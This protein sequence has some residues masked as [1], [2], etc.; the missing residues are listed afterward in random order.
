MLP[1]SQPAHMLPPSQPA[2]ML[3]PIKQKLTQHIFSNNKTK[4]TQHRHKIDTKLNING[5]KIETNWKQT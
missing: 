1:P 3:P 5:N 2:H 4:L